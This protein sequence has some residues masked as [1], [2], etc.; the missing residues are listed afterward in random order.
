MFFHQQFHGRFKKTFFLAQ[1]T[2]VSIEQ[3]NQKLVN[4]ERVQQV[5]I[6]VE[7]ER[8]HP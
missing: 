4:Q 7:I 2:P 1:I 5:F 3:W 8:F 6:I